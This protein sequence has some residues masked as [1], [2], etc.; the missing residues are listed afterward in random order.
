MATGMAF[1]EFLSTDASASQLSRDERV[2]NA[3]SADEP[4]TGRVAL[5][6][7]SAD[8]ALLRR[9]DRPRQRAR[10][11]SVF[12][13]V[14]NI[15]PG[16]GRLLT[17]AHRDSDDAPDTVVVDLDSWRRYA[18]APAT[19]AELSA[20]RI[21]VGR[22]PCI[23]LDHAR[24]WHARLADYAH[25]ERKLRA[26]L[27]LAADYL[28]RHGAGL[29]IGRSA[30]AD[31]S[32]VEAAM[33]AEFRAIVDG[34]FRALSRGDEP[35]ALANVERL[36]GL[37]TG[38]TPSG[39]D[40]LLGL[41]AALNVP[42]SPQQAWRRI[43]ARVVDGAGERTHLVSGAALRHAANGRVRASIASLCRALMYETPRSVLKALARV[44]RIGSGSGAEIAFGVLAGFRLHLQRN[45][46]RR[47][48]PARNRTAGVVHVG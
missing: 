31:P 24:P 21:V 27:P 38:L 36:L 6:A 18:V 47:M 8:A 40:V 34:L 20:R 26:N 14:I 35:L 23:T 25:D 1:N 2:P 44:M 19:E 41:L 46:E 42:D 39:D 28:A 45:E 33:I 22:G 12:D 13:R 29:G 37:G 3:C 30:G 48:P 32:R 7:L 17:L 43:G 11:H 9:L 5:R 16:D 15:D 4:A 10:V